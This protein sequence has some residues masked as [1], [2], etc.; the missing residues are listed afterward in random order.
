MPIMM[1]PH[2]VSEI[3]LRMQAI[4]IEEMDISHHFGGGMYIKATRFK[5]GDFAVKHKHSFEHLSVLVSGR[6][7]LT[8]DNVSVEHEGFKILT[9]LADKLHQVECLTDTVWLCCHAT[10][11]TDPEM[12]DHE[13]IARSHDRQ[14]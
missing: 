4:K 1:M 12:I 2:A 5:A 8:V 13:L 3:I 14:D 6:V 9:V 10:E 11:C 7:K